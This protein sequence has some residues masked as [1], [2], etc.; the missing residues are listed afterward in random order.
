[1]NEFQILLSSVSFSKTKLLLITKVI[2]KKGLI[3]IHTKSSYKLSRWRQTAQQKNEQRL[4]EDRGR[5]NP[6]GLPKK[7]KDSQ[8]H[9]AAGNN[10]LAKYHFS[11]IKLVELK[12]SSIEDRNM[13][14]RVHS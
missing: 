10:K 7:E 13:G 12:K 2:E 1:M 3:G 5:A 8:S 6:G 11:F 9:L 14:R 4:W